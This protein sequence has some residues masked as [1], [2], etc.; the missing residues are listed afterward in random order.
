MVKCSFIILFSVQFRLFAVP[1]GMAGTPAEAHSEMR[2]KGAPLEPLLL[3][4][5]SLEQGALPFCIHLVLG[6]A[7]SL[8]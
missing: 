2:E 6:E 3:P 8:L 5:G 7:A 4:A 1:T